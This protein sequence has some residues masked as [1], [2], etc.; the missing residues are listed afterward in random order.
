M[1]QLPVQ[2]PIRRQ[3]QSAGHFT[4]Q[5]RSSHESVL[6]TSYVLQASAN[7][8]SNSNSTMHSGGPNSIYSASFSNAS[9]C[10]RHGADSKPSG[11]GEVTAIEPLL[12]ESDVP[13]TE[14]RKKSDGTALRQAVLDL[15]ITVISL[16]FLAFAIAASVHEGDPAGSS[17]ARSLLRATRFVSSASKNTLRI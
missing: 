8:L 10:E 4:N 14:C 9:P 16:Y 11:R 17:L 5:S 15:C 2:N 12:P 1:Q 13:P 3:D 7:Q 6:T